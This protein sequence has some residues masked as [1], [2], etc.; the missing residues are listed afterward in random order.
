MRQIP[1]YFENINRSALVLKPKKPFIDWI[2]NLDDQFE[3]NEIIE[4]PDIYL[5]PDFEEVQQMVNWLKKNYDMIFIDQMNNWYTDE[6]L[7]VTN[8][9]FK[10][11]KEWFDFSLHTMIL[12]TAEQSIKKL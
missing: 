6:T 5:L 2:K 8:R 3:I 4:D 10:L 9:T 1:I 11:F 12:D 7:W